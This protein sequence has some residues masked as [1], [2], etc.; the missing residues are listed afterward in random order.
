MLPTKIESLTPEQI[1]RLPEF[2]DKWRQI[3]LSTAPADRPRAEKA[4]AE[5]YRQGGLKPPKHIVW[6]GSPLSMCL[7][8]EA[9]SKKVG[10]SVR[11]SVGDSVWASVRASVGAS[12]RA[13]VG[14]SVWDSVGAS[15]RASVWASVVDSVWASVGD[16]VGASVGDSVYGQHDA[17]G[18]GFYD[19]FRD[20]CGLTKQTDKLAGLTELAHSAGWALPFRDICFVSERHDVV[21]QDERWRLHCETGPAVH[22]PDGFQIFAWHGVRVPEA[23]IM[24]PPEQITLDTVLAEQNAE[25]ARVW[26]RRAGAHI[27]DDPR[28]QKLHSDIDGAGQPRELLRVAMPTGQP[29]T[30]VRVKCPS[31]GGEYRLRVPPTM[32]RCDESVAWTFRMKVDEYAP[33]AET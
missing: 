24:T 26:M 28:V 3:G 14:D 29:V 15:V 9:L 12:V 20:A 31:T 5:M 13:S 18:L 22:Y 23:A 19:Y 25:V 4:I 21:K 1:A 27:W 33:V 10:A 16:S 17:A 6:C 30:I 11:A 2:V 32:T 7:T 8:K